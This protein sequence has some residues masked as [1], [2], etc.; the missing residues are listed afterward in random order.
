MVNFLKAFDKQGRQAVGVRSVAKWRRP[1]SGVVK[2]NTDAATLGNYVDL[3][4]V[5]RNERGVVLLSLANTRK[6]CISVVAAKLQAMVVA[7]QL[8]EER[9]FKNLVV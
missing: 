5:F 1:A 7:L 8:A 4:V 9:N 6:G 3:G 2:V